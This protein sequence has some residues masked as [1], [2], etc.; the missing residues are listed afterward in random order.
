MNIYMVGDV[1]Q[2][3]NAQRVKTVRVVDIATIMVG[4]V[5]CVENK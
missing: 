4:L 2:K 3:V 5:V 1:I